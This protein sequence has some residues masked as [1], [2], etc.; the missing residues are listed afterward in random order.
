MAAAAAAGS[1]ERFHLDDALVE[2]LVRA[3]V[4]KGVHSLFEA[5]ISGERVCLVLEDW[6]PAD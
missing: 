6:H 4:S 3:L 1:T 2:G 5:S